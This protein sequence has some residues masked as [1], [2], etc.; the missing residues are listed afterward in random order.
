MHTI[1]WPENKNGKEYLKDVCEYNVKMDLK[2]S[3]ARTI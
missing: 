1:C 2:I 3:Q